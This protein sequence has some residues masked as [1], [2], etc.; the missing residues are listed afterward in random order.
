MLYIANPYLGRNKKMYFS[1][2]ENDAL[3]T[4]LPYLVN[5]LA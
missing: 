4:F 1:F 2:S 5:S 3:A